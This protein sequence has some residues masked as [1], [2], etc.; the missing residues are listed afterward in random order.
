MA[1]RAGDRGDEL[2]GQQMPT[3]V[4]KARTKRGRRGSILAYAIVLVGTSAIS[5]VL[6]L[7]STPM[8]SAAMP[9][10]AVQ[11]PAHTPTP[12]NTTP[13]SSPSPAM[14]GDMP[15]MDHGSADVPASSPSPTSPGHVHGTEPGS[16]HGPASSPS[17]TSPA[18]V[19]GTEPGSDVPGAGSPHGKTE[20]PAP[21]RPVAAVL[22][23][24]GGASS[25]V[26]LSAGFLRRK[27][28][29]RNQVKQ[30]ARAARGTRR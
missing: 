1:S 26:L 19:H 4:H 27:D 14:S 17:P 10:T 6:M 22:G 12:S 9:L 11:L 28:R 5:A 20:G 21:E 16:A 13:G 29:A 23:T 18:H 3:A 2:H 24:F 8:S 7:T 25:A 30:A 15:G